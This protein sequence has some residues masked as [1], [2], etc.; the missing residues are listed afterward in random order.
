MPFR[1]LSKPL[2]ARC[3]LCTQFAGERGKR[4]LGSGLAR[5]T[6][7]PTPP[8][9]PGLSIQIG[10]KC[11]SPEARLSRER[12]RCSRDGGLAG[13]V[14]HRNPDRPS[15]QPGGQ[16]GSLDETRGSSGSTFQQGTGWRPRLSHPSFPNKTK[17]SV[18][19]VTRTSSRAVF[20]SSV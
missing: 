8:D 2:P 15:Q 13:W 3:F 1:F 12:S 20:S 10:E 4:V 5:M 6:L 16:D 17:S 7:T 14:N 18:V 11:H 19:S 9:S